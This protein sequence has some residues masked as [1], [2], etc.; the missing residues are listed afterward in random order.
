MLRII[1]RMLDTT[2][3]KI[4]G[5]TREEDVALALG[6][7]ANLFGF[8]AYSPSPRGVGLERAQNLARIV[9]NGRR[10][11]VDVAP[12]VDKLIKFKAAGFNFFQIHADSATDELTLKAWSDIVGVSNLWL[13]PRLKPEEAFPEHMLPY[14]DTYLVDTYS[15][16][17]VGGT[18]QTGDWGSFAKWKTSYTSK[19]WI[20]AGGLNPGNI[21]EAISHT[22]ADHVDVNSGVETEP[23]KKDPEK[24][25]ALFR[26]LRG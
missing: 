26:E 7:G 13:A 4:C 12:S 2:I 24:L 22:G 9:P 25:R 21:C 11:F 17:Q 15:S 20:L 10:V 19:Q 6:L 5:L 8:I 18:G 3:I 14:A 1:E 23:G 16:G